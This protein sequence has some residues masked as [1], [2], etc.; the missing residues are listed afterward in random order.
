MVTMPLINPKTTAAA[1]ASYHFQPSLEQLTAAQQWE[2]LIRD[3][4][5]EKV[6]ETALEADFRRYIIED[7]LRYRSVGSGP[8]FT[9]ATKEPVGNGEVDLA[10]GKFSVAERR[11]LAPFELKGPSFKNL[12]AI[13]PGR[14]KTPVQQAWEYGIDAIGAR[15]VLVS[16]QVEIRLYAMGRGRREYEIF[17]LSKLDDPEF[18]KRFI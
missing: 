16:N 4:L 9:V 14:A 18:L 8:E 5:I 2:K 10:L 1:L 3:G 6:R 15:W 13:M 11:I 7:I 17:E 12:D